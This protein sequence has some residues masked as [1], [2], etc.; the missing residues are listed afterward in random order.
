MACCSAPAGQ[1]AG[2]SCSCASSGGR[3]PDA[4][5]AP[6]S[7]RGPRRHCARA[8]AQ[9][10]VPVAHREAPRATGQRLGVLLISCASSSPSECMAAARACFTASLR[11]TVDFLRPYFG[12]AG[13]TD[14]V[15]TALTPRNRS[16]AQPPRAAAAACTAIKL[17]DSIACCSAIVCIIAAHT[18]HLRGPKTKLQCR[19]RLPERLASA[20]RRRNQIPASSKRPA[21]STTSDRKPPR[22]GAPSPRSPVVAALRRPRCQGVAR[23]PDRRRRLRP[24]SSPRR[25]RRQPTARRAV[26]GHWR[27]RGER[28]RRRRRRRA[29]EHADDGVHRRG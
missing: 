26:R 24:W 7:S 20:P 4:R 14:H 3:S 22:P 13:Q 6:A 8:R 2:G 19:G 21:P 10:L 23:L 12:P 29:T 1:C 18:T 15:T 5:A 17:K 25:R 27:R 11:L 16:P 9:A 28:S